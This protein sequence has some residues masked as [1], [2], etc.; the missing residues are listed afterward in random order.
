MVAP[1]IALSG[2]THADVAVSRCAVLAAALCIDLESAEVVAQKHAYDAAV[3][4]CTDAVAAKPGTSAI[5]VAPSTGTIS[6][7]NPGATGDIVLF[8]DMGPD[9]PALP[10][11]A[12]KYEQQLN[13]EQAGAYPTDL[14]SSS[15][16]G[17]I[18]TTMGGTIDHPT[19]GL[20]PAA[21]SGQVFPWKQHVIVSY[22][23]DPPRWVRSRPR[24]NSPI[25]TQRHRQPDGSVP[26]GAHQS[27][28]R[29][30]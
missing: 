4:R 16:R 30:R 11:E 22:P 25:R 29:T 17:T 26:M 21:Q 20:Y 15:T 5:L 10:V 12:G 6:F 18:N 27:D 28:P 1:I 2:I 19:L 3:I 23:K 9:V 13:D 14:F 7:A 8:R 24:S